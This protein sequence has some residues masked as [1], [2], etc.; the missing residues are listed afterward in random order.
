MTVR[1]FVLSLFNVYFDFFCFSLFS[2][3]K[4][5]TVVVLNTSNQQYFLLDRLIGSAE[6]MAHF[7]RDILDGTV[8]VSCSLLFHRGRGRRW[9]RNKFSSFPRT[10]KGRG[11]AWRRGAGGGAGSRLPSLMSQSRI[12]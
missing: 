11:G 6:D 2:E 9:R 7:I 10:L 4:V 1:I 5:P 3:L 8:P 12:L